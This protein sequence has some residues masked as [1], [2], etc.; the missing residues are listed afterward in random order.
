MDK[1]QIEFSIFLIH[2]LADHI[3]STPAAVY[4]RLTDDHILDEYIIAC[5]DE[6][7]TLGKEYLVDDIST[8]M[9]ERESA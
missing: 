8:F 2:A 3:K 5:Y 7:H 6:L 1:K 4:K 9:K